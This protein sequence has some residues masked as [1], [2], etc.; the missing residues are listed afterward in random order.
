[1]PHVEAGEVVRAYDLDDVHR[2]LVRCRWGHRLV[3]WEVLRS[4]AGR[5]LGIAVCQVGEF[6]ED[7]VVNS[8]STSVVLPS[9]STRRSTSK[10]VHSGF[11]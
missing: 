6:P 1:M 9:P 10:K 3:E 2:R 5:E 7:V 4:D 8:S 11:R